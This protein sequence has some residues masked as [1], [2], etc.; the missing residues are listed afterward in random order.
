[1]ILVIIAAWLGYKRATANSRNGWL[2]AFATAGVF[3]GAQVL[4]GLGAGIFI[5]IG[6]A[7]WSWP[8]SAF[9]DNYTVINLAALVFSFLAVWPLLRWLDKPPAAEET[10]TGPP[11]PPQF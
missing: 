8:E 9:D 2:W 4:V 3:L 7:A 11:P 1:M 5:A 10:L 6:V